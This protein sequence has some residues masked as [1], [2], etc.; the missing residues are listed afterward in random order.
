MKRD[1]V[2]LKQ[3]NDPKIFT[4]HSNDMDNI[5]KIFMILSQIKKLK[6]LIMFAN[7]I[8][9]MFSKI[10]VQPMVTELFIRD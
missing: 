4:E 7:M 1:I 3:F 9:D 8:S 2:A 6:V 5:H 10:K